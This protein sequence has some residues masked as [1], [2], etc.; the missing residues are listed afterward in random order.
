MPCHHCNLQKL[1][2][3]GPTDLLVIV[4]AFRCDHVE[5]LT[6]KPQDCY[7]AFIESV[8]SELTFRNL[9]K[10]NAAAACRRNAK[11]SNG[12]EAGKA[13]EFSKEHRRLK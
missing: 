1:P 6:I 2:N 10:L 4:K 7:S 8:T 3:S 13:Q 9:K 12:R 5:V 11:H